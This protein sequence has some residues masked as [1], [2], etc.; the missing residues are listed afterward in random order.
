MIGIRNEK[1]IELMRTSGH[2]L[3]RALKATENA[4][5]VGISLRELNDVAEKAIISEGGKPA[6]KHYK[7]K[8][9]DTP[10]PAT[11][12][13]SVNQEIV[14]GPATRD[15]KLKEGDV[16]SIDLGLSYKGWYTDMAVTIPIGKV[17]KELKNLIKIT[18]ESLIAGINAVM[19]NQSLIIVSNAIY[20]VITKNKLG[21]VSGFCGHGVGK[22]VHEEPMIPNYPTPQASTIILKPG[23]TLAIEP[24]V[25]LGDPAFEIEKDGWTATTKDKKQAAHFE[26]TIL[27]TENGAEVLTKL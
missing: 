22:K 27:V 8:N 17:T 16:L 2:M 21:V 1:E 18:E 9:N 3:A 4:A 25:T 20:K 26:K 12:C 24:M 19:P 6:F 11:L 7:Q 23:M 13:A 15:I 10:F 5:K 14:H